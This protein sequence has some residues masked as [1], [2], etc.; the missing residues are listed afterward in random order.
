MGDS[1]LSCMA[2]S[3]AFTS[4]SKTGGFNYKEGG[5]DPMTGR[6]WARKTGIPGDR[7]VITSK[8]KLLKGLPLTLAVQTT[9]RIRSSDQD[10]SR[11]SISRQGRDIFEAIFQFLDEDDN[12]RRAERR[13]RVIYEGR[14]S[15]KA[16]SN[17]LPTV[18]TRKLEAAR[19]IKDAVERL[20]YHDASVKD[21]RGLLDRDQRMLF[22]EDRKWLVAVLG[23]ARDVGKAV[24]AEA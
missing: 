15:H 18:N 13:A 10:V 16:R 11:P 2:K 3:T 19:W 9:R 22:S 12:R 4:T 8:T 17:N 23:H 24:F 1:N 7:C 14:K 5:I 21:F 6:A 20:R